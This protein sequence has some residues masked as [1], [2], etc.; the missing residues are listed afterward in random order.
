M[1]NGAEV[2]P[3]LEVVERDGQMSIHADA[4]DGDT[5]IRLPEDLLVPV[6]GMTWDVSDDRLSIVQPRPDGVVGAA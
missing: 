6:D 1:A 4:A 5:L 2:H 3:R